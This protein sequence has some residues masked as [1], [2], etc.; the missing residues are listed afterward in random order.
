M[1]TPGSFVL[2]LQLEGSAAPAR[3][4]TGNIVELIKDASGISLFVLAVLL[5]FSILSWAIVLYKAWTSNF[6]G[7][8]DITKRAL[9]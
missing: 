7:I 1:P 6:M 2:A 5:L 4:T 9:T 3:E 8:Q